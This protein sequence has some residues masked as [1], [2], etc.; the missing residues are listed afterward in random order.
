MNEMWLPVVRYMGLYEVSDLGRVRAERN[1]LIRKL[2]RDPDGYLRV[3][4]SHDGRSE[5]RG[6]HQLVL[7]AFVGPCP[8]GFV[9][10]HL[11]GNPAN[12]GLSNLGYGTRSENN[13]DAVEHG[14]NRNAA[15]TKCV[16]GHE[17]TP[18]NT[19]VWTHR[20]GRTMRQC[21]KCDRDRKRARR[22]TAGETKI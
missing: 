11:D 16:N 17:F 19:Y 20:D 22:A 14:T 12:N 21:R 8:T 9:C 1:G 10:R 5:T 13:V 3:G 18:E 2:Y 6:V 15:K 4:L 7:A